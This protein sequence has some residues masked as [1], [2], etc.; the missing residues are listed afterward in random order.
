MAEMAGAVL[1][2]SKSMGRI[3]AFAGMTDCMRCTSRIAMAACLV[4]TLLLPVS[5]VAGQGGPIPENP[6]HDF[7]TV[8]E[9]TV[10]AHDFIIRNDAS[11]PLFIEN[12]RIGCSCIEV[13][14]YDREIAPGQSGIIRVSFAT[15]GYGGQAIEKSFGVVTSAPPNDPFE[16][17][18]KGAV[19]LFADI[20]P[21]L[22]KLEGLAG[23][24]LV[25]TV[26]IAP[27]PEYAFKVRTIRLKS[28]RDVTCRIVERADG[29]TGHYKL[30]IAAIRERPGRFFDT[31]TIGTDHP[32]QPEIQIRIFGH[33]KKNPSK[34]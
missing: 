25:E 13:L 14:S 17:T 28:G 9:G 2:M 27:K 30:E 31:V 4:V 34:A 32:L 15:K 18:L 20:E 6:V 29:T 12:F 10:I 5:P 24:P 8:L 19:D 3:P 7:G 21:R 1:L 22:V 26:L 16:L 11:Q 33:L 23:E